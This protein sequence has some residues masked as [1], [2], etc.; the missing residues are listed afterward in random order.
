MAAST[1][2]RVITHNQPEL[3]VVS[4]YY[5]QGSICE[6]K[7]YNNWWRV[8]QLFADAI[9]VHVGNADYWVDR[10]SYLNFLTEHNVTTQGDDIACDLDAL[11]ANNKITLFNDPKYLISKILPNSNATEDLFKAII[12]NDPIGVEEAALRG[13]EINRS[14]RF[15]WVNKVYSFLGLEEIPP[16]KKWL[17][18]SENVKRLQGVEVEGPTTF[19]FLTP[20]LLG[21]ILGVKRE[22][23]QILHAASFFPIM[24]IVIPGKEYVFTRICTEVTADTEVLGDTDAVPQQTYQFTVKTLDTALFFYDAR[25]DTVQ[26]K[27]ICKMPKFTPEPPCVVSKFRTIYTSSSFSF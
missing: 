9:K 25:S 1:S 20:F 27:N 16:Y 7:N 6:L 17:A 11:V 4:G 21:K 5:H 26:R 14:G 10:S 23:F 24:P 15:S 18:W 22:I 2:L 8:S 3:H 19:L 13:A 12:M